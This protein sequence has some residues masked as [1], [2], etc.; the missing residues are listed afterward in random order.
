MD[1]ITQKMLHILHSLL[2]HT[3]VHS[4]FLSTRSF[5][6]YINSLNKF[7]LATLPC[8]SNLFRCKQV[9]V[10]TDMCTLSKLP[11]RCVV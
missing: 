5:T 6:L 11:S 1:K 9:E 3:L 4:L 8:L 7:T 2:I 10:G